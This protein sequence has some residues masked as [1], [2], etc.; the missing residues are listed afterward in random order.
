MI[1]YSTID[2]IL[3]DDPFDL[4]KVNPSTS[5]NITADER[6]LTSFEEINK[7]YAENNREPEPNLENI[8]EQQL[9]FR[10]KAIRNDNTKITALTDVDVNGLLKIEQKE[11]STLGDIIDDDS[12]GLLN[13]DPENIFNLKHVKSFAE[14]KSADYVG[15]RKPC[16]DFDKYEPL[17]KQVHEDTALNKRRVIAF[18]EDNLREGN[19]YLLKGVM[20]YLETIKT[21]DKKVELATGDRIRKDGRTRAIFENGTESD[22]LYRSLVKALNLDGRSVTKNKDQVEKI[23]INQED[24]IDEEDVASGYIYIL[25]SKSDKEEINSIDNLYK[26]GYSS[27]EIEVRIKNAENEPTYLM[28]PVSLITYFECYNF[29]PKQ[30]EKSLHG[31]FGDSQLSVDVYDN[32][33]IRHSPREWFIAPLD[34]IERAAEMMISGDIIDYTYDRNLERIILATK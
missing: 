10:L 7:F 19:F 12:L 26:I 16:K 5:S 27:V 21:D 34:I 2:D 30:L 22:M 24:N 15:K 11:I 1:K 32:D 23:F 29:N 31:F 9:Y 3:A 28:A 6:L 17:F 20:L 25:K 18:D 14:R 33:G 4:L 13:D 8:A